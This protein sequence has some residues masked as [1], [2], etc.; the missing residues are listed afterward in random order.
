METIVMITANV[1]AQM[2]MLLVTSAIVVLTDFLD[3]LI[4]PKVD[5]YV[6]NFLM[7]NML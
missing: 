2:R 5:V 4:V 7:K 6:K 1:T 3:F